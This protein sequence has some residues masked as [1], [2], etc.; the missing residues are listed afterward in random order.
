MFG[1][2]S[3]RE[4][5][6]GSGSGAGTGL[7]G[8]KREVVRWYLSVYAGTP[9]SVYAGTL[10]YEYIHASGGSPRGKP[11][12]PPRSLRRQV[13]VYSYSQSALGARPALTVSAY[14][15]ADKVSLPTF[16]DTRF[17]GAS[18]SLSFFLSQ[19]ESSQSCRITV[20]RFLLPLLSLPFTLSLSLS[21]LDVFLNFLI[22]IA[23]NRRRRN[24]VAVFEFEIDSSDRD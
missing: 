21:F 1:A 11:V 8:A 14:V 17:V 19:D 6:G 12:G 22:V 16:S 4:R 20:I 5:A 9:F 23:D 3:G 2:H 24:D 7:V 10:S 18:S 13:I 15:A